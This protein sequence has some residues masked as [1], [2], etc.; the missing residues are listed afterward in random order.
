MALLIQH[1]S[2]GGVARFSKGMHAEK[3]YRVDLRKISIVTY[4]FI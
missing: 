4:S 2:R 1:L 3:L